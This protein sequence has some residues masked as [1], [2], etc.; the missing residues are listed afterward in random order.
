MHR[1]DQSL[2]VVDVTSTNLRQNGT[3][4]R[5]YVLI[6]LIKAKPPDS[7]LWR[8]Q[9]ASQTEIKSA[10]VPIVA[11]HPDIS[12]SPVGA[13]STHGFQ[14]RSGQRDPLVRKPS[15]KR[16]YGFLACLIE[17]VATPCPH[18]TDRGSGSPSQGRRQSRIPRQIYVLRVRLAVRSQRTLRQRL[19]EQAGK[20]W[21]LPTCFTS[22]FVRRASA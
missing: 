7:H 4:W 8:P 1:G 6:Q 15:P 9:V 2:G 10:T 21:R 16:G 20:R 13:G 12:A 5:T 18:R 22:S 14:H 17:S 11:L 3:I 19:F